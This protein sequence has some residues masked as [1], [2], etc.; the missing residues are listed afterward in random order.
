[1]PWLGGCFFQLW[2]FAM[3]I[4]ADFSCAVVLAPHQYQW[5]ASPQCGVERIMLDR[6][7][8]EQARATSIVRYAPNS[9]F[10]Q[11]QH[12][13]G[14]EILVLD[15]TFSE[16]S[17]DYS[18][19][20]YLRNPPGSCHRPS[21]GVGAVLFVKLQQMRA[22][23]QRHVRIDTRDP[24][25]W[26]VEQGRAVCPLFAD[27]AEQVSLQRLAPHEALLVGAGALELLVLEGEVVSRQHFCAPRSWMR[28]PAGALPAI[29]AGAQ[30]ATVYLK[31]RHVADTIL[32]G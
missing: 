30:G 18:A 26:R 14:E 2:K 15:G 24:A 16:G 4:N 9:F 29:V 6:I 13:G 1:M 25:N 17:D 20:W 22:Y 23:E 7:G 8:A 3:L 19:G 5:V 31:V 11:H 27:A 12:P 21:S 32:K 28:L 10:P